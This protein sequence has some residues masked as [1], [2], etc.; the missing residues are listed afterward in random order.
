M[1]YS[2]I[3]ICDIPEPG[4]L[5]RA[6]GQEAPA[7]PAFLSVAVTGPGFGLDSHEPNAAIRLVTSATASIWQAAALYVGKY[8]APC[9]DCPD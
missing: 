2:L 7:P 1:V 6:G 3:G 4:G 8:V 9:Q 5:E